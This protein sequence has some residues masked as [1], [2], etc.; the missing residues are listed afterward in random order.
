M[1]SSTRRCALLAGIALC[2]LTFTTAA[3]AERGDYDAFKRCQPK[4]RVFVKSLRQ[5]ADEITLYNKPAFTTKFTHE[6]RFN[7]YADF[8]EAIWSGVWAKDK[9]IVGGWAGSNKKFQPDLFI[10]IDPEL[11]FAGGIHV[12][13]STNV[14]EKFFDAPLEQISYK[15]GMCWTGDEFGGGEGFVIF[16]EN[17]VITEVFSTWGHTPYSDKSGA[18]IKKMI[19][20]LGFSLDFDNPRDD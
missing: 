4:L 13:A 3:F 8:P 9:T 1:K 18:F 19:S 20:Q 17:G 10:T 2:I 11:T 6:E 12:G 5:L 15:P 7:D 16:Y 14:L